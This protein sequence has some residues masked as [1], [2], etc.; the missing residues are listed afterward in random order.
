ME[1]ALPN[2][3]SNIIMRLLHH[4][5][6]TANIGPRVPLAFTPQHQETNLGIGNEM[7]NMPSSTRTLRGDLRVVA[8]L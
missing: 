5:D 1:V 7:V 3:T 4:T 6:A 2:A 8:N